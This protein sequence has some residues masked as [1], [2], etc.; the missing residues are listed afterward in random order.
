LTPRANR[1][2]LQV[3]RKKAIPRAERPTTLADELRYP[4][5]TVPAPGAVVSVAPGVLWVRMPLPMVLDH[6]NLWLLEDGDGWTIIDTGLK[7]SRIQAHWE[8]VFAAHLDGK[9]VKRVI[10]THMHPDHIGQ[11]GWLC[12]HWGCE[13]WMTRTDWLFARM[14]SLEALPEPPPAAVDFYRRVGFPV[15]A[16]DFFRNN[17][18]GNF[19][20]GVTPVPIGHRRIQD[21]EDI[22]IG[23]RSWRVIIGRGHSPEH[24]C[25]YAEDIGVLIAGDM[26]LPRISPH[27]GVYPSEPDANPLK[28]FLD[29][30]PVIGRLPADTL[31]LPSHNEPFYGLHTRLAGLAHHH[32]VRLKA[33]L[34]ALAEE[35]SVYE[36]IPALFKR[37]LDTRNRFFASGEAIAH[38]H[39]LLADGRIERRQR[40]DGVVLYR[41][42]ARAEAA[43]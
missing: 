38:V 15:D 12:Q 40:E 6:I 36:L 24:A 37:E 9:K 27:I 33:L 32:D 2:K 30:L 3:L 8:Q 23:G 26:V 16:L 14:L 41:R 19:A 1:R 35:R 29:S 7:S 13:L 28:D 11:A 20:K 43:A 39:Y 4:F 10:A 21:G 25:L 18:Y 5:S 17:G 31:V 34:T 42:S 22:V